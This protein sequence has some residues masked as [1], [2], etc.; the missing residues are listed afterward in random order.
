MNK[1]YLN[2][3]FVKIKAYGKGKGE[4]HEMSFPGSD[5]MILALSKVTAMCNGQLHHKTLQV[6]NIS[7]HN[8]PLTQT[9]LPKKYYTISSYDEYVKYWRDEWDITV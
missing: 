3:T 1:R 9:W 4:Q 6:A 2:R 8:I 7:K 5:G